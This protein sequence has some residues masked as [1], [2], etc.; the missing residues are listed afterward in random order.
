MPRPDLFALLAFLAAIPLIG[1]STA[2]TVYYAGP[3]VTAPELLPANLTIPSSRDCKG[4]NGTVELTAVVDANGIPRNATVV[5]TT[6]GELG[7]LALKLFTEQRFKPGRHDGA[8]AAVGIETTFGLQT[9]FQ[10]KRNSGGPEANMPTLRAHPVQSINLRSGP[11]APVTAPDKAT[12]PSEVSSPS[13]VR[14]VDP[15]VSSE[16][17]APVAVP[18]KATLP[19][20]SSPPILVR[21]VDPKYTRRAGREK[22]EGICLLKVMI[23]ANGVPQDVHVIK[24]LDPGLDKNAVQAVQKYRFVPCKKDGEPVAC[25]ITIQVNFRLY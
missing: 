20:G 17:L 19:D 9:C 2:P 15:K 6:F 5:R 1:Q 7:P 12:L 8:P 11:L 22:I 13:L 4:L 14:S 21:S 3:G 24:R 16:P 10:H 18:R 23:D 25:P